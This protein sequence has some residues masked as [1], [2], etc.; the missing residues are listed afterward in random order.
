LTLTETLG[1]VQFVLDPNESNPGYGANSFINQV[2]YVYNTSTGPALT[3][4]NINEAGSPP[5]IA[6]S[7]SW[8]GG[9]PINQFSLPNGQTEAGYSPLIVQVEFPTKNSDGE[10]RFR[11]TETSTWTV[12]GTRLTDFTSAS[13][14]AN[15]K[16]SPVFG[17]LSLSGFSGDSSNW[18]AQVPE[19]ESYAMM[20]VGIVVLAGQMLR[21]RSRNAG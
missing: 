11:P 7:F 21:T 4:G 3:A 1:G 19:P 13:A 17:V 20:L 16:P 9:N 2:F 5:Q 18:V 6:G 15:S 8:D 12:L 14:S 10:L